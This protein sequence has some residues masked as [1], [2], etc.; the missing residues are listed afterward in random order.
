MPR[1][2]PMCTVTWPDWNS[3]HSTRDAI[4][5]T[6]PPPTRGWLVPRDGG[7]PF[8]LPNYV[9]GR[10]PIRWPPTM[11]VKKPG[12]PVEYMKPEDFYRRHVL[13][14]ED[15]YVYVEKGRDVNA[16]P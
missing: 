1:N 3:P 5:E 9:V 16:L 7:P 12:Q 11:P 15:V 13:T 14:Q 10:D 8:E 4:M 6:K 2:T